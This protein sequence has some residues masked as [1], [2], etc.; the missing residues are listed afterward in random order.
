[1]QEQQSGTASANL[2]LGLNTDGRLSRAGETYLTD[3]LG[4]TMALASGTAIQ[5]SYGYDPYGV[6]SVTGAASTN[7]FQ[8]TGREND[9]T[10]AGLMFYRARYYNPAW[11]RFVSEDPIGVKGG[12]NLYGYVDDAPSFNGDATGLGKDSGWLGWLKGAKDGLDKFDCIAAIATVRNSI[13]QCNKECPEHGL[14]EFAKFI[15]KYAA[16]GDF[17]TAMLKCVCH[18]NPEECK[19]A[20]TCGF[21]W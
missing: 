13:A 17:G 2:L 1:M 7:S 4:S 21:G 20:L 8:Y 10:T 16:N 15:D 19:T 18:N 3:L 12:V 9:G 11:G 14:E 6:S 5:T